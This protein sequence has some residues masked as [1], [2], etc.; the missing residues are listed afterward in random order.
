[1]VYGTR[2]PAQA[3][4]SIDFEIPDTFMDGPIDYAME[5]AN[6]KDENYSEAQIYAQLFAAAQHNWETAHKYA[7]SQIT[8][9]W[10]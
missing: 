3:I 2:S 10:L 1:M 6:L 8:N 4:G 9:Q 5:M 7:E